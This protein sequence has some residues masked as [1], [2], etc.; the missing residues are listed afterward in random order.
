MLSE[1]VPGSKPLVGYVWDT[2]QVLTWTADGQFDPDGDG[3]H[4][5]DLVE[6]YEQ[7]A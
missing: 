7:V 2:G 1:T 6:Y 5:L 3:P 4:P